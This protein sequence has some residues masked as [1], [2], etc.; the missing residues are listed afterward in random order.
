MNSENSRDTGTNALVLSAQTPNTVCIEQNSNGNS[1][2]YS[3]MT[4]DPSIIFVEPNKPVPYNITNPVS[5]RD[6]PRMAL[7]KPK[8]K[9]S[10]N[11]PTSS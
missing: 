1:S 9:K 10:Q 5:A 3:Q 8:P 6:T 11:R 7:A 2:K 4:T